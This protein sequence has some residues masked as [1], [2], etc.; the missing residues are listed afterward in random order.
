M[1]KVFLFT[2]ICAAAM[3]G[4]TNNDVTPEQQEINFSPLSYKST[5]A[6]IDGQ[7]Y[8]LNAPSFGLFAYYTGN[9]D[10]AASDATRQSYFE[11]LPVSADQVD[12]IWKSTPK[13]Y[14][15]IDGGKLT[16]IGY[17][18][19]TGVTPT[20][21]TN[22]SGKG[23]LTISGFTV[24]VTLANLDLDNQVDL[25]Y[26]K[27]YDAMNKTTNDVGY[28]YGAG[29]GETSAKTGVNIK[30]RH[31]LTQVIV[32]AK[33]K[34]T[35]PEDTYSITKLELKNLKNNGNFTLTSTYAGTYAETSDVPDWDSQSGDFTQTLFNN[36][37]TPKAIDTDPGTLVSFPAVLVLP[38]DLIKTGT[39][40]DNATDQI[41]EVDLVQHHGTIDI[42]V[43][44]TVYLKNETLSSFDI[45]KKI[46]ITLTIG[47][48][49]IL[50]APSV[51]DWDSSTSSADL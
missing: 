12:K 7:I 38:Q 35:Y 4:C 16:F 17:S 42:P 45:N 41:I 24:G 44:R 32:K 9:K 43:T 49:E 8:D 22:E 13:K 5:K 34:E 25:L 31:A 18:P 28:T 46:V 6:I 23:V 1:K 33:I 48:D 19:Y 3:V 15:P 39:T 14:W 20:Y 30:F 29:D 51:A 36:T 50:Y 21:N 47:A 37:T 2:A 10:W 27:P 40:G 26:S 11:N